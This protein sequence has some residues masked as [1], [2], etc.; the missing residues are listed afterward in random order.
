MGK[1]TAELGQGAPRPLNGGLKTPRLDAAHPGIMRPLAAALENFRDTAPGPGTWLVG[2]ARGGIPGE[3]TTARG[4]TP[5]GRRVAV[6]DA[7]DPRVPDAGVAAPR[8]DAID[9]GSKYGDR[10]ADL[11]PRFEPSSACAL[12]PSCLS[13]RPRAFT[14]SSGSSPSFGPCSSPSSSLTSSCR[15]TPGCGG[16]CGRSSRS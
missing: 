3:R 12:W 6:L 10:G 5:V 1:S 13:S 7:I 8:T 11:A 16:I 9:M 14:C 4:H 15:R 2:P